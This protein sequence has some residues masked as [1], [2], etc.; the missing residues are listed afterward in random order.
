MQD[1]KFE[2]R[3]LVIDV[4]TTVDLDQ[5]EGV[6]QVCDPD[7]AATYMRIG[8]RPATAGSSVSL[9]GETADGLPRPSSP[10]S[11]SSR[12]WVR[13]LPSDQL[14]LVRVAEY[15][16]RAQLAD[17][18][19]DRNV[20]LL[21]DAAHLT[22]PFIGQGMGAGLR[23]AINLS[24]KLAGV[25]AGDLPDSVLD[26]YETERKPHARAMIRLAKLVGAAMT[27]GG[28]VG[29]LLRR[30]LAPRLH[31]VP[32]VKRLVL[33]GETPPLRHSALVARPRLRR[34]LAGRLCPNPQ[35]DD[36]HRL[37]EVTAGRFAVIT[38]IEPTA[39]QRAD[40]ADR[41]AVLLVARSGSELDSW[42]RRGRARAAIVRPDGTVLRA[43]RNLDALIRR[44][45]GRTRPGSARHS[46]TP[47]IPT[48]NRTNP[49]PASGSGPKSPKTSPFAPTAESDTCIP[50]FGHEK[51]V[52]NG[53]LRR[54]R[55]DVRAGQAGR[56]QVPRRT[57]H[58]AGQARGGGRQGADRSPGAQH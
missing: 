4:A 51:G 22:P 42:L 55:D 2:Q 35:L 38:R 48:S 16:F 30:V 7:R 11:R 31:H 37:D 9:D 36:G 54:P 19:R 44:A 29:D 50:W 40:V 24:W 27:A 46:E 26:T 15:T 13:A 8:D 18:W 47:D 57:D 52:R 53:T 12:P 32:G 3:W 14:E 21:G 1:L 43:G 45:A 17:R 58:P 6:H 23:D 20:F 39:A 41:G 56:R 33:D 28:E 34:G 25:L 10:C 49:P 5:W